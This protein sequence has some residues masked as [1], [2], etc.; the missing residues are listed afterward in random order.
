MTVLSVLF[1]SALRPTA[2]LRVAGAERQSRYA[3]E[4]KRGA[5]AWM[6]RLYAR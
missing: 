5:G 4:M 6:S 3:D 1:T 2:P